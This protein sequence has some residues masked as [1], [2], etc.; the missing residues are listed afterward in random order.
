MIHK[1]KERQVCVAAGEWGS[2]KYQRFQEA[3]VVC[4]ETPQ[5]I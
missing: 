2:G 3:Q 1:E 4:A 5:Q